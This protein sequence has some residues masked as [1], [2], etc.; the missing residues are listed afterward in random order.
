[1][2]RRVQDVLIDAPVV[3]PECTG[4]SVYELFSEDENLLAVAV[5]ENGRPIGLVSRDNFFLR[6]ADRHGRALFEK[7]PITRV[8]NDAPLIVEANTSVSDLNARIVKDRPSALMEGF[9]AVHDGVFAGVGTSLQLFTAI[10]RE[11]EERAHKQSALAEQLGRARIEA[12]SASK[13]KSEFLAMMSHEIRTPLNGVLG[14]AQL[15]LAT[16]LDAEQTEFVRVVSDSEQILLRVLNDVLDLSKIEAG[17]MDLDVQSFTPAQLVNDA[18]T[19]W[20]PQAEQKSIR[21]DVDAGRRGDRALLGDPVRLKQIL[22]NL[23][24]K[25]IKFTDRGQVD[26]SIDYYD[27]GPRRT[28]IH[29]DVRDTGCGI[30]QAD[31]ASVFERFT[32]TDADLTRRHGGSGLGLAICKRLVELMGGTIGVRSTENEGSTFWF[33]VPLKVDTEAQARVEAAASWSTP[34]DARIMVAED[35]PTNRTVIAGF[36]KLRGL[37]PSFVENGKQAVEAVKTNSYDLV[38]MDLQMPVMDG[39]D[40]TR[41]IRALPAPHGQTPIVA[42]TANALNEAHARCE[43]AGMNGFVT[44]PIDRD[45]LYATMDAVLAPARAKRS[46]AA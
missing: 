30:A 34:G 7:R 17:R 39:E 28:T 25:A 37:S 6:M 8:M 27:M 16:D 20:S 12:V 10:A 11:S 35:N 9:I 43:A 15:L 3:S 44:K 26:V 1:M 24:G 45:A 29:V 22:F 13:A 21:L 14:V 5:V 36:L 4:E 33:E 38:F 19:L 42:L 31:Q 2:N 23:I 32:Q 40:A 18:L 46:Q 41:R